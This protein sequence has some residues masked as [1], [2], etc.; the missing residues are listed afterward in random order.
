MSGISFT[1]SKPS[2][3]EPGF[4]FFWT[5]LQLTA[6]SGISRRVLEYSIRSSTEYSSRK[7]CSIRT[8]LVR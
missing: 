6:T 8:T 1:H 5:T 7:K 3:E 2:N 4:R